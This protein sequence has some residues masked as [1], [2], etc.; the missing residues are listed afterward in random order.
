MW[1]VPQGVVQCLLTWVVADTSCDTSCGLKPIS[2]VAKVHGLQRSSCRR[3]EIWFSS[4]AQGQLQPTIVEIYTSGNAEN[5]GTQERQLK[6]ILC[7]TDTA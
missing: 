2:G 1:G 3:C 5:W 7:A 4:H 6:H